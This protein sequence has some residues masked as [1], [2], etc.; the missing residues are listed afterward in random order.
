MGWRCQPQ[1][2]AEVTSV[3]FSFLR[4]VIRHWSSF[5]GLC[6]YDISNENATFDDVEMT[7]T[8]GNIIQYPPKHAQAGVLAV[9]YAC[10]SKH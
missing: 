1:S 9:W 6:F 4:L 7:Y 3:P 2:G 5:G 8:A 10:P